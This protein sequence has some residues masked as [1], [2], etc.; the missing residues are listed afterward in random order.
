[1]MC[2]RKPG[3]I[4]RRTSRHPPSEFWSEAIAA[5]K[6]AQP[7]FIFMAEVYWGLEGRLQSL[8]FDYTYDKQ[9]YDELIGRHYPQAQ[10]Q[11][12]SS[13]PEYVAA[14]V[15]FLENHDEPIASPPNSPRTKIARRRWRSWDCP[16]CVS[17]TRVNSTG[18]RLKLPVQ[19]ARRPARAGPA[20]SPRCL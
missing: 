12:L 1:M 2:S 19:L 10:H 9:L 18:A 11:L 17:C 7:D 8:G 5:V 16:E 4:C 15:H 13:P 6:Q 20:G 3:R 14:S